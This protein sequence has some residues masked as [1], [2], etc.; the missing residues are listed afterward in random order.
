MSAFMIASFGQEI[1]MEELISI[2][3]PIY[4]VEK[5]LPRCIDS[6]LNQTYKNLEVILVD[7][8]SIDGCPQICDEY[9]KKDQRI[10]VIHKQNGGLSDARNAG[11]DVANGAFWGFVDSDDYIHSEMYKRLWEEL[12]A[13]LADIAVCNLCRVYD[14]GRKEKEVSIDKTTIYSGHQAVSNILD[15]RLHVVSVVSCGKLY[16]RPLFTNIR[17]PKG[18]L[19]EDEFITYRLFYNS[20]R[21]VY[22]SGEYYYYYQ[23]IDSIMSQRKVMVSYDAL[24]AYEQMGEF[25]RNN[26]E[27][28]LFQAAKYKYLYML[29][30]TIVK[31]K[32]CKDKDDKHKAEQLKIHYNKEYK[33][34]VSQI[35]GVKRKIRLWIYAYMDISI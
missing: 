24:E 15:K 32:K 19:H 21:V 7:D 8:G 29:K 6:I 18:K 10:K 1:C 30:E 12:K 4:N 14:E 13:N 5:Y 27:K 22:L 2:I 31:L 26:G 25:F 11:L 28:N 9:A 20:S 16:R 33:K 3:V 23:R 17:F 35:K 34:Y